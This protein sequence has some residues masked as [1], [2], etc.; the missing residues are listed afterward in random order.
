MA[1]VN[2]SAL[3]D[4][5]LHE[6]K[7]AATAVA[8]AE[9]VADGAGSGDWI[10]VQGWSQNADSRTTVGTP[11]QNI[12]TGARTL[13]LNDGGTTDLDKLPSDIGAS[14][15]LWDKVA[16]KIVPI[17]V[18]DTYNIRIGFKAENYAGTGPDIKIELDIGGGLG[19]IVS[20]TLP[21]LRSGA[22]QSCLVAFPV[23]AGSTFL[24]N[25]GSIYLTYT[26]TG[27]CDIFAS[28]IIIIRES[29]N[30]V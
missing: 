14:G 18:F 7:G 19:T 10:R 23:F 21:L 12:A 9:Y 20:T 26:G 29:K 30:Y 28:D 1:N 4:P 6:P 5:Y 3:T 25:G 16:N 22:Q 2:H 8:G 13:W 11:A 24:A 17:A 27:T 15:H